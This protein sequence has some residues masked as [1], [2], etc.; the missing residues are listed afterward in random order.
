MLL[1]ICVLAL[2]ALPPYLAEAAFKQNTI[3]N[4]V[5]DF[6]R[7][8]YQRAAL[9]S[10]QNAAASP[11]LPDLP[12]AVQ[13]GPIGILRDWLDS[14]FN[15]KKPLT[16]MGATAMGNRIYVIGGR[17]PVASSQETVADVWS[18]PVSTSNGVFTEDW[19]AEQP[20]PALQGSS[21]PGFTT[22]VAPV[23]SAGVTSVTTGG[24]TGYIY[25]IGGNISFGAVEFSSYAVRVGTVAADG[26]VTWVA[27]PALPGPNANDPT[28]QQLGAESPMVTSYT[29]AGKTYVYVIG[30]LRRYRT[31]T[32]GNIQDVREGLKTV[33]Y[34]RVSS[35]GQLVKPSNGQPGWDRQAQDVIFSNDDTAGLWDGTV[36]ADHF[37]AGTGASQ[38]ALYVV[39]GQVTPDAFAP[40]FSSVAYRATIGNDGVLDWNWEGTLPETRTGLSGVPFRGQLYAVG[41]IPSN[42]NEPDRGVLTSYVEDDLTLHQFSGNL[43]PGT[44]SGGS[45]FLR[46]DT[47]PVNRPRTFHA[48]AIVPADATSVNSAFIYVIGGRGSTTDGDNSDNQ[49]SDSVIYGKIGGSEDVVTTGYASDG[50]YYSQPF[51]INFTGA[52]LQEISWATVI[53]RS[54]AAPDIQVDYRVTST[55]TC[56]TADWNA[57]SWVPLDGS[58]NDAFSSVSGQNSAAVP[59]LAARCFQYR[60]KLSTPD[61]QITPSLLNLSIKVFVPGGPDLSVK[62]L[63]DR[64]SGTLFTGLNVLIQNVNTASPPTLSADVDGGGSFYVDLCIYGPNATGPAPTLP[65]TPGN[66][67][68]SKAYSQ[69]DKSAMGPN[70]AYSVTRWFSTANDQPVELIQFFQQP[71]SYTVYAAVDSFV[72]NQVTSPKGFVDE[73]D[74]GE[75]NNVSAAFT[76]TVQAVGHGIYLAQMRR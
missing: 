56:A 44:I 57:N 36:M 34:A 61:F 33:Y 72:D 68:C 59:N 67:Q 45:N 32:G 43:P 73:G 19:R 69:V 5:A 42:T 20:L 35:G 18:A 13:L 3:D 29:I 22:P 8:Q 1:G 10:L 60:A 75:G 58:P 26:H 70:V 25:V 23:N 66:M 71:G 65:L 2:A 40:T 16:R 51:E 49:A 46:S 38:D 76:F 28:T 39:G 55:T 14:P 48:T 37:V 54:L 11:K 74:Q 15:L 17:T 24:N 21:L 50:W 6:G 4:S 53:D 30:G 64:R 52:Q 62:T 31:G 47:L 63:S 27:G 12:G 9:G 41:G 7:G